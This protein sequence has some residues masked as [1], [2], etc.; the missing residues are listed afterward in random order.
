MSEM[1]LVFDGEDR[2][3]VITP[4]EPL[5]EV[6]KRAGLYPSQVL[7]FINDTVIPLDRA[8]K[9]NDRIELLK[10]ISGG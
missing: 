9:E 1:V 10:V 2:V 4:G 6:V 8:V 3:M 5:V 7:P